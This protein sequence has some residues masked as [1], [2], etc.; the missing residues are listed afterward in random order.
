M[1]PG[2]DAKKLLAAS[3]PMTVGHVP[4]GLEPFLIAEM[5]KTGQ[6]IAYV[7]SDGQHMADVEQ[8]LGFI[9]P[10]IPVLT[11]PAWDCL[12]Y[13]RVSP[14]SDTSA[15]RLAALSSLI[16]HHRKPHA[17]I[18]LVTV[19]AM[20][21]KVAPQDIIESLAFSARPGNQV[22]MDDIAARLERNGFDRVATV[23][24]VGEYAVRGG[25]LDVFVPGTEE[26][27][28]LDFFGD[29]LESIRSFD[30]AS[31]RTT[32]QVR[33]L[34]LNP[35]SEVTLTP[36]TISR[37]RKNYLSAFGAATRDDALY[38]AVSEGRRY[39]GMEHWLPLFYEK[40]ETVFDYLKGFRLVTDHTVREAAEERSKLVFDYYD[41]RLHSGQQAK[42]QMAQG[43]PYKPVTPGQLYLDGKAFGSALDA[44]GAIRISPFNEHEG[45]ARRVIE[46]DARQGP[47][48]ARPA[49][50]TADS[51]RV[52]VFDAVV[53]HIADKRA[54][55]GKVLI[56][57]WTEG[58]LDRLLQV[59]SE[60]GLARVKTIEA[61]KDLSGLAKGEAA[62]AV[63]SLEAG[64]EAGDLV[65]I[66]EQ[67]ILGDRMVRRSKRRKR[68]ADFISEVAGLDEGS[69]VVHAEHGIGRFVG[70]RT[71]EAAGAPHACLELQYADDAKLF[72]PVE[73][74]DLLSRFGGEG[75]EAQL[76]K[77][78]GGAWQMRKAKL[79]K[80]LLDIAGDLIRVAAE[81]LTR[82]APV[83]TSPEGLYDEFAARFPY[84]ETDD[85]MNAIEAVR[86]DLGAG[87]PM[88][89][90]VCGDVGFGKTEVAL[91][92]AFVAAM[93]GVQVAVV[94]P[95]TLL[96]RQHFK[97]FS[98]RF[99]GLPIRV[100]QA[101]R[102]VGAKDLA[103]TKKE[104]AEGKTDIVVGTHALLGA[105]IK[106]ANLGLLVIDEEQHFG[107]KH[108][109]RLKELKSD[110][111]V[112][113]LS[114]TPI[115]R[116]LQLA[117]TGVRELSLITTP[118]VDRMAVRTFIS[119]FDSLV[120]RETLMREH[121]R[122]GQSFYVCP[123]LADLADIHAFLQSDV[124]ELKVAVAHGQM[125]A[126]ELEDIMNAF[127]E[128]RYDVLLSTTIVESGL[129]VPTANT[130]IVH[131]ADMFGLAQLYQLRGRVGRSKV[132]AFALFTLPVNK[133][134][135]TTAERR[136]KVLQ[137]LDTLGAGFQLASHDLDIRGAGNLLGEEQSGHIKEVGFE[138]YQQML[139]EAVAEVKGVDE[140]QDTG[141]SPQISVGTPV[142]I[143]DDY[144]PDLHLRMALYRRLGEITE[145]KEIDSF[146]AEMID[147]FGPLPIEVQHLLKIV[148]IKSLCRIANVEKLDAGPK[149]VVVQFR[150]KEFPNPPNLVGYI[151]KQGT[152][153]KIRP[154]HSVFLTRDLPT[155]EKR[156]QGAAVV[157][158]QLAELAK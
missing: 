60:H 32:G 127:Y 89:R 26:P 132:R 64:F 114:A 45:E 51:E 18:V 138:L 2:F 154:D 71:I 27:V 102:L 98:E 48:W 92:A 112:L 147:R 3:E 34:D 94:V 22:R 8:M 62:A 142:M 1:I 19:N 143:P 84:D 33:S 129:D 21:Q 91:R 24:E 85:Q 13:D 83:L 82:H 88:D 30:P 78:G 47:R 87:R 153:A 123:R 120:I 110:V 36:D 105:G 133:V 10:E 76:D 11:L 31:Q 90:L 155:P 16:A 146:G 54:A 69:I 119:P 136:L 117:M 130:L 42:G 66:G 157:M 158:T 7:M 140:I 53:K 103:L 137:S 151:A 124:P 44:F 65:V 20:L 75:T 145:L 70:L 15:R 6:P 55:G 50:D 109:E 96:A 113:T 134:L 56:S 39:A 93:N 122:G 139:E 121:Y 111:H 106:F 86:E 108:K 29:T 107:V 57:A 28:R 59:L 126:G 118:P 74:I 95:T 23:R 131:R 63:L 77:L 4:A 25:I 14:S 73:N 125:P 97:T 116:T 72:L 80:R 128:G 52:N 135:T 79:K 41:A 38:L 100:Q 40:L 156:L 61:F 115:P 144:V 141:W 67:D 46:L 9:A 104:V 149:G 152:M 35:M 101:S 5:A 37:F 150:N 49:T 58:S 81:R 99:R 17:A 68:A 12:P 148:Y 43:T